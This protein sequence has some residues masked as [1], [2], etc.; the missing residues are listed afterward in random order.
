MMEKTRPK[1]ATTKTTVAAV[2]KKKSAEDVS[3]MSQLIVENISNN[4]LT[5]T[6]QMDNLFKQVLNDSAAERKRRFTQ[7]HG[8]FINSLDKNIITII[9]HNNSKPLI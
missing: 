7:T 9:E 5:I 2:P 1:E 8:N 3:R 6:D 4:V